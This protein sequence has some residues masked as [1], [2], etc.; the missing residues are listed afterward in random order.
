[1]RSQPPWRGPAAPAFPRYSPAVGR[2]RDRGTPAP[3]CGTGG[4]LSISEETIRAENTRAN[5]ALYGQ[6]Y[7]D[8]SW[9]ICCSDMLIKDEEI[10]MQ[11]AAVMVRSCTEFFLV[12]VSRRRCGPVR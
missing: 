8:E 3:A 12:R 11:A 2:L 9:A 1:L 6:E 10:S 7:N 4:R 5:L